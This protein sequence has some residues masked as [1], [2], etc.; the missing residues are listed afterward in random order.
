MAN[1]KN[2]FHENWRKKSVNNTNISEKFNLRYNETLQH[3]STEIYLNIYSV[4]IN[5][6]DICI[7][8][9]LL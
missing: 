6:C 7:L 1:S 3:P 2:G 8:N 5:K 9:G 4:K